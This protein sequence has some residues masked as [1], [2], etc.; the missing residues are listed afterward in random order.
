[1]AIEELKRWRC[2]ACDSIS[3]ATELLTAP[4]PF[5]PEQ[6]LTGCPICKHAEGFTKLCDRS[7][8]DRVATCG[9]PVGPELGGYWRTCDRHFDL[10]A[11][12]LATGLPAV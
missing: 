5:N 12:E 4:N 1:M 10:K 2:E 11:P 6:L 7:G 3:L 9:F 8:C